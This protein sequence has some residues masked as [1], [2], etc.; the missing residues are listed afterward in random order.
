MR[1]LP[2]WVGTEPHFPGNGDGQR[3]NAGNIWLFQGIESDNH[4]SEGRKH[5]STSLHS[6]CQW[7]V[8]GRC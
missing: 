6:C 7:H 2:A 3:T 5:L 4:W 8:S 1:R